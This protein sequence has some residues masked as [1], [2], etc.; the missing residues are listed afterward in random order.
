MKGA[1]LTRAGAARTDIDIARHILHEDAEVVV[2]DKPP[3]LPSTGRDLDDKNCAQWLLMCHY[4]R[5][6][7]AVHQ[8]DANTSGVLIFARKKSLV[9]PWHT[10]LKYPN[11]QKTYLAVCHGVPTWEQTHIDAPLGW[12]GGAYGVFPSGKPSQTAAKVFA[13][14]PAHRACL[15]A[16]QL[17]T[18]RTHQVR[19]HLAHI[20]HPLFGEP[21]Y[22]PCTEHPRHAL[23]AAQVRLLVDQTERTWRAP[24]PDDLRS[25][26]H[27]LELPPDIDLIA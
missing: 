7:W 19:V 21:H 23:H 14:S 5:Q 25:L 8:L 26:C 6:L 3:N 12:E 18:G 17:M 13:V 22:A 9:H 2:L 24:L 11:G 10:R 4:R 16:V 1:P 15:L 20:G 27:R